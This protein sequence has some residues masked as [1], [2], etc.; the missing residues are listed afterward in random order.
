[1][2][3]SRSATALRA[4]SVCCV[5]LPKFWLGLLST[6]TTATELSGWRSSRVSD[7]LESAS[8]ISASASDADRRAAAA[9]DE[10]HQPQD[11]N[12]DDERPKELER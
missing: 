10:Q 4:S 9:G 3:P 6:T 5:R 12:R 1:M 11:R 7:G 8:T 2:R